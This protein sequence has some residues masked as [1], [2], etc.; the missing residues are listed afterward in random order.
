MVKV[1][2]FF[3]LGRLGASLIPTLCIRFICLGDVQSLPECIQN[4]DVIPYL[5]Y[6]NS[7]I[8]IEHGHSVC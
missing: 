5:T 6:P 2:G 4:Q 7:T 1:K 8:A 3:Q